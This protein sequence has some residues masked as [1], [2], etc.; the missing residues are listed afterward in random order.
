M[1]ILTRTKLSPT[2]FYAG[3]INYGA[4][5]CVIFVLNPAVSIAAIEG[6]KTNSSKIWLVCLTVSH[7]SLNTGF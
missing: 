5:G 4:V 1:Y 3:Y 7:W 2:T 6:S